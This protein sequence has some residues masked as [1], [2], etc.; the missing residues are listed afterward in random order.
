MLRMSE[1]V[2]LSVEE[3]SSFIEKRN[4]KNFYQTSFMA[5]MQEERGFKTVYLG[6]KKD[7]EILAAGMFMLVDTIAK[8][9]FLRSPRGP[10]C[11]YENFEILDEFTKAIKAYCKKNKYFMVKIDPYL[12]LNKR[13]NE[14]EIVEGE[15]NLAIRDHLLSLGYKELNYS[16]EEKWLYIL[17]LTSQN[18]E[19]VL[20]N[21]KQ[22]TRNYIN[23]AI[24]LG[25]EV[26]DVEYD[27]LD[28]FAEV[29]K[30]TGNRQNIAVHNQKYYQ[31]L[32]KCFNDKVL[33]KKA[34][35]NCE[36]S[37]KIL[38]DNK[39][40]VATKLEKAKKES[41]I[42]DLQNQAQTLD[43]KINE[44]N[45]VKNKYGNE[46]TLSVSCFID[47]GDEVIY[48]NGGNRDELMKYHG[49]FLVQKTMIDYAIDNGYS[50]YNF[51]GLGSEFPNDKESNGV[52]LFKKHFSGEVY[53]TFG[54]FDLAASSFYKVFNLAKKIKNKIKK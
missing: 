25:V 48:L 45:E 34:V 17:P 31:L 20:K 52:Y 30:E 39:T 16:Q 29:M 23:Q 54:E 51:Y 41:L 11:D 40:E 4:D 12:M 28:E 43:K 10:I 3:F 13:D 1:I 5:Q 36:K 44:L 49:S 46:V 18:K 33:F 19:S 22:R 15:N 2:E 6:L 9:K 24:R 42:N 21:F 38:E 14:G 27:E 8:Q 50:R 26:K 7:K 32:Y 35:L 47:Y 37:L 53:E